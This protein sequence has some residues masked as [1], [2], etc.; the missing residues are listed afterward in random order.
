MESSSDQL[1]GTQIWF[2]RGSATVRTLYHVKYDVL[3]DVD[4]VTTSVVPEVIAVVR[5]CSM[6]VGQTMTKGR[7]RPQASMVVVLEHH[8]QRWQCCRGVPR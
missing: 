7:M 1:K 4:D 3:G 5:W 8:D 6:L 2:V